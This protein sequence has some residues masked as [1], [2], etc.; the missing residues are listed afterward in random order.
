MAEWNFNP[1]FNTP[2]S[3]KP[4]FLQVTSASINRWATPLAY[5][6]S[7]NAGAPREEF[8]RSV[9][10]QFAPIAEELYLTSTQ[11]E[12][13]AR[14]EIWASD[15]RDRA[16]F[17]ESTILQNL[18]AGVANPINWVPIMKVARGATLGKK[19]LAGAV[20]AGG[21]TA[22]EEGLRSQALLGYDPVEGAFNV[23]AATVLGSG[24]GAAFHGAGRV[25]SNAIDS[26]HRR[27]GMHLQTIQE[28][29]HFVEREE[30][31][32]G[33]VAGKRPLGGRTA[34]D[35]QNESILLH[36]LITGKQQALD[37]IAK[38]E[39][40]LPPAA[41]AVIA[42]NINDLTDTRKGVLDELV[43]KRLDE[44]LSTIDDPWGVAPS[45]FDYIDI[46]ATPSKTIGRF[47]LGAEATQSAIQ[48][49]NNVKRTSL[50]ISGDSS[51]LYVGQKS[52]LTL[53][54]SVYVDT[55]LRKGELIRIDN[56]LTRIWSEATD[57]AG[58]TANI[59]RRATNTV[60]DG[61]PDL[62]TWLESVA[63]KMIKNDP[64]MT[65]HELAA[66]ERM[67]LF[68]DGVG[69]EAVEHG[70]I[71]SGAFLKSKIAVFE[72][73]L[74]IVD[75]KIAGLTAALSKVRAKNR[76][77][78][79]NEQL[80]YWNDRKIKYTDNIAEY[81]NSLNI[82]EA[83]KIRPAG[84]KEQ[85]FTRMWLNDKIAADEVGPK[86]LRRILTDYVSENPYG[87][88]YN[89][90]TGMWEPKDLSGDIRA[91]EIYVDNVIKGILT[92]SDPSVSATSRSTKY[93]S[94]T[95]S[96]PNSLVVE[97]I[98]TNPREVMRSYSMRAGSKI[99][100]A[101]KFGNKS[102]NE[103]VGDL[104]D[105][106]VSNGVKVS[107][108][109]ELQ[110]NMT[111]LYQ[112]LTSTT[113]DDPTSLTNKTVQFIKE[114]T[115]LNYLGGAGVTTI[116]DVPKMIM[117]NT[118][119]GVMRGVASTI[120]NAPFRKQ[121]KDVQEAYGEALELSLGVSQQMAIEDTGVKVL[122]KRWSNVK[123]IGFFANGL[124]PSTVALKSLT[125]NLSVHNFIGIAK[126]VADGSASKFDLEYA[127]RYNLSIAQLKE[128]ASKAPTQTTKANLNIGNIDEWGSAGV[129]TET[130]ASFRAAVSLNIGNTI[131]SATP[132][133]RFTYAD[134]NIFMPTKL[135]KAI[136]KNVQE[137]ADFPGYVK[138]QSGIMTMPFQ[139]YNWPMSAVS[140]ILHTA[141]QGQIR[142]RYMGFA[143][144]IGMG[145][146]LA[147][148]KT[149]DWAWSDMSYEE[150][151]AAAIERSGVGAIYADIAINTVRASV[152]A[153]I[154]DPSNDFVQL[155]FYGKEGY[156]GAITTVLG[157]GSST[158]MDG[159][160]VGQNV[161]DK[162]Y[163]SAIKHSYLMLPLTELFWLKEDS[164]AFIN[165]A[166][167]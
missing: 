142:S 135:A 74:T 10:S 44:G 113:L 137:S 139:F 61:A 17:R 14:Q 89:S 129:S 22:V 155:P 112:R 126:R 94:R 4:S 92:D 138:W 39:L 81:N 8:D 93:P 111:I 146:L 141:A 30:I 71:G 118:F 114:F 162:E 110:K 134:G 63:V 25:F 156:S 16:V 130:I 47:K 120:E 46:M 96:I 23:G 33:M 159:V 165:S 160:E 67:K 36:Q 86:N 79:I 6:F 77:A 64:N 73:H 75:Q 83:G 98:N 107:D 167:R 37:R 147:K 90:K 76:K 128:I 54:P 123:D 154:N 109:N 99:D 5:S 143:S 85:Y 100:F 35:L 132:S 19:M 62:D 121:F 13:N 31:L 29:E 15:Q 91:Q 102:Y 70:V 163:G 103:V 58:K 152:Q 50:L 145:Y 1:D 65:P 18:G 56:D 66:A 133:S 48:A 38:G 150:R 105:D 72:G 101:K 28:M 21:V 115:S 82:V 42:R 88:A 68:F 27:L 78:E 49:L 59:Y 119:S 53:P 60:I 106:L 151:F 97:F 148:I 80:S 144:M 57:A 127:S 164:R 32:K 87:I 95:I 104:M 55:K 166:T 131:M 117:E 51:T 52:G 7:F 40:N 34:E 45:F 124:G 122:S 24:F 3:P 9:P 84:P 26:S 136:N 11:K 108:A 157:A 161:F 43:M 116:G 125:G 20:G 69:D 149:P 158:I 140:N 2:I 41:E 153:G 12:F